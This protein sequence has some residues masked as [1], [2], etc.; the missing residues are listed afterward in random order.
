MLHDVEEKRRKCQNYS[1]S[2]MKIGTY[3]DLPTYENPKP[4]GPK[5]LPE[6]PWDL[7]LKPR[8]LKKWL[9]NKYGHAYI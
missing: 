5:N 1:Y 7:G 2:F 8:N 4:W 3:S 6:R 9:E